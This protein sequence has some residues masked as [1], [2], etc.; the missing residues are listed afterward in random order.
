[1]PCKDSSALMTV[2][3][4]AEDR[5]HDYAFNK[6]TCSRDIGGG[7]GYQDYCAGKHVQEILGIEFPDLIDT[8]HLTDTEDQ[9]LVYLEWDAL[10]SALLQYSGGQEGV[11]AD[12]YKIASV[13]YDET[14]QVEISLVIYPPEE[15][16]K[17]I[18]SCHTRARK[19]GRL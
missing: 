7:K 5:L 19:E 3:L 17:K 10:R 16:P 18:E 11:D 1:M 2:R 13:D 8:L 4:D 12:R 14:G 6:I 9:F 15:M